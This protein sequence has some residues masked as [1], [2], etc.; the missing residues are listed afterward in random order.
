[1]KVEIIKEVA[2]MP[3]GTTKTIDDNTAKDLINNGWAK[4]S[5]GK[6]KANSESVGDISAFLSNAGLIGEESLNKATKEEKEP[7][8]TKE[9][10]HA[11]EKTK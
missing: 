8:K 6:Y 10:K 3:V 1:M 4:D 2:G 9:E 7:K 5:D 11:P